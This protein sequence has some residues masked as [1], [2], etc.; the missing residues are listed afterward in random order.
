[1]NAAAPL[2]TVPDLTFFGWLLL[3]LVFGS[4]HAADKPG[5]ELPN[6]LSL[7]AALVIA[8]ANHPDIALA[9]AKLAA[10]RANAKATR[11]QTGID[12]TS[13]IRPQYIDPALPGAGPNTTD[14][15]AHLYVTKRLFDFG[16]SRAQRRASDKKLEGQKL[17]LLSAR[18]Q[19]HIEVRR[20]YFDVLLADM[21][22]Q[23]DNEV[24]THAY[25]KY[26][27]LRQRHKQGRISDV[28]LAASETHYQEL[29]VHRTKSQI[30]QY[31]TRALLAM[32]LNRP[33]SLPEDLSVPPLKGND[34]KP[35]ELEILLKA[36]LKSNPGVQQLREEVAAA[37]QALKAAKGKGRPTLDAQ[38]QVSAYERSIGARDNARA[39]L[40][41][42]V[43]IYQG[44]RNQSA[45]AQANAL[46]QQ[47]RA[48][49]NKVKFDLRQSALH[50]VQQLETLK[51]S[52]QAARTRS[53]YRELYLDRS[54]ALYEMEAQVSL[55]DAMIKMTE[56]QW[57]AAK[58]EFELALVW[59]QVGALEGTLL[60]KSSGAVPKEKAP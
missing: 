28:A 35:P 54:R 31:T 25:I 9:Q 41:L 2:K 10:A 18:Q 39:S 20:R 12:I 40:N 56:A 33:D 60:N 48:Q 47:K 32:A 46:L 45:V 57:Q 6:P 53:D 17:A 13:E 15:Q 26:D 58:V 3:G 51:I 16:H 4:V 49:L 19:H 11:S 52:R 34:R 37:E 8:D 42:R 36:A 59:A 21:R 50:L 7:E 27:R 24:M 44:G 14:S 22:Y 23:V 55:G 1:V 38:L 5:A 29:L 43:P 30:R